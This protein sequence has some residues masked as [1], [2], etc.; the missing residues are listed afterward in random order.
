[1]Y[2]WGSALPALYWLLTL[3]HHKGIIL[4]VQSQLRWT[5][6]ILIIWQLEKRDMVQNNC[7]G[8]SVISIILS[9]R[10]KLRNS[11]DK[12]CDMATY[13]KKKTWHQRL[14][15]KEVFIIIVAN[16]HNMTI[17][18]IF[19]LKIDHKT[20]SYKV[21]RGDWVSIIFYACKFVEWSA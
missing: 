19:G 2:T 21:P 8:N 15:W 7:L 14:D 17:S 11:S 6:E 3:K 5:W 1:M 10:K 4:L 9:K 12:K 18:N 20:W 13:S 16:L